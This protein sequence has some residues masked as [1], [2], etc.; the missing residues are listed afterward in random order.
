MKNMYL[1]ILDYSHMTHM[2]NMRSGSRTVN[3]EA[4]H[5]TLC[6]TGCSQHRC[7]CLQ[8]KLLLKK[9]RA[10]VVINPTGSTSL[11]WHVRWRQDVKWNLRFALVCWVLGVWDG[12]PAVPLW[13]VWFAQCEGI[14]LLAACPRVWSIFGLW[15]QEG[16][17]KPWGASAPFSVDKA[18]LVFSEYS[19]PQQY[20]YSRIKWRKLSFVFSQKY[21][22]V[23]FEPQDS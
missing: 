21:Q 10:Q 1:C 15:G 23:G 2:G 3:R 20:V 5:P 14:V 17:L 13:N 16:R 11:P 19:L 6:F 9:T 8:K 4:V 12:S 18:I 7:C 22:N